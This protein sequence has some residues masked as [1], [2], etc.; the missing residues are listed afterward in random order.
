[1][2]TCTLVFLAAFVSTLFSGCAGVNPRTAERFTEQSFPATYTGIFPCADCEGI[3]YTLNLWNDKVFFLRMTYLGKGKGEGDR[4]DD[5]GTWALSADKSTLVLG[6]G[7][8][9]PV[10]FAV[11]GAERLR[12]LDLEGKEVVSRLNY[13]LVRQERFEW[14]EPRLLMRG[15]YMYLAD[16][17]LFTECL[18][19]RRLVVAQENDNAA[20]EKGYLKARVQPGKPLLATLEGRIAVRPR[21]EGPGEQQTLVVERFVNVRPGETCG[22]RFST[23]QLETT[24]WKLVRL[25]DKAVTV[26][27]HRREPHLRLVPEGRLVQGFGGC[28]RFFGGYELDGQNLRFGKMGMT[29]MACR[30]G[31]DQ[32]QAFLNALHETVRWNILG[33]RLELYGKGGELLARFEERSPETGTG[34]NRESGAEKGS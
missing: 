22:P 2:R 14:F 16:A 9:A 23:A 24:Y 6:G 33:E 30:D 27:D 19:G 8:E 3:R 13:D 21:M 32:E 20:L 28:N 12:K 17:G 10:M 15:M 26:A 5:I 34:S 4:F 1:M 7:R 11:K 18:T 25:G 31:M 29:R